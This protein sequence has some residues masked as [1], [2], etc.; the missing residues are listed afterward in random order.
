MLP[1]SSSLPENHVEN[2]ACRM[3]RMGC[4]KI[5]LNSGYPTYLWLLDGHTQDD[6]C[7]PYSCIRFFTEHFHSGNYTE[8]W[9][10][11]LIEECLKFHLDECMRAGTAIYMVRAVSEHSPAVAQQYIRKVLAKL[12]GKIYRKYRARKQLAV[13]INFKTSDT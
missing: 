9:S 8:L 4:I 6:F 2:V 11:T 7:E 1:P 12:L 5:P 13:T 10:F 3:V